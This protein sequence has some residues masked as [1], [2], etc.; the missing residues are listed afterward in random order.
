[1]SMRRLLPY[2]T[3][4][5]TLP[6]RIGRLQTLLS[7]VR[8]QPETASG[9]ARA[10]RWPALSMVMAD[11]MPE[12][13]KVAGALSLVLL[14]IFVSVLLVLLLTFVCVRAARRQRRIAQRKRAKP[15]EADDVWA[16][17]KLPED[18]EDYL[19]DADE[20]EW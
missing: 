6:G 3:T 11:Q 14:V 20:Q 15:T 5:G 10:P 19:A 13:Q 18:A 17:H 8:A 16:M 12:S 7:W 1:M 9:G 2:R 4:E